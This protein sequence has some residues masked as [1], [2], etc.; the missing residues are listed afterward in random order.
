MVSQ[1]KN[2]SHPVVSAV[3]ASSASITGLAK[4]PTFGATTANFIANEGLAASVLQQHWLGRRPELLF[5]L[6]GMDTALGLHDPGPPAG[7]FVLARED[8]P[9]ARGAADRGVPEV[10]ERVMRDV[11]VLQ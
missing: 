6:L 11:V 4:A 2:P 7:P 3:D 10:V 5:G 1:T 9:G 8:R